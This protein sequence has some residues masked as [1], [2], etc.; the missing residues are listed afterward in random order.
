MIGRHPN[1]Q[2]PWVHR[3]RK[4]TVALVFATAIGTLSG[5]ALNPQPAHALFEGNGMYVKGV[6][7]QSVGGFWLGAYTAPHN[8]ETR[9][10]VWCTHM[11]RANPKP[12]DTASITDLGESKRW[13]PDELDLSTAQMA[14]L[15]DRYQDDRHQENRAALSFLIHA[16]FE[17]DQPGKNTQDSVNSL[18]DGVRHQLPQVFDRAKDYVRQAKESAVTTYENG[19]VETQT[20]RSG[21]LKD[22]GVKNEKGEWIPKLKLHLMLIGPARF[23][24]TGTSQWDGETQ[25]NAL[26]LEWEA[27]GNGT[28]KWVGN[29]ENPVR[30]TLTKYGVNPATQDT[31]SYGNRP[32]GDKEEKRLKGG[33]WKVLMDFQ[34]MGRSQVAQT[35]VKDNTLSDTVTAFADPNYG[36]GKWINDEHGPIPVTFEGTAY[37][38]GTEPPN[39]P[40]DTRFISK[41]MRV[42]GSTTVVFRGEGERQVSIPL[43]EGQAK[44]GFVSWVWRVRKEDQGQYSPLIHADW[45]DQLGLTHETQVIPW[46]IQI[47]SAAQLKETNGG[48]FLI[49]DLWVSGFPEGHTYWSGSERIAADTS[50]MRHRLL[51]FPQGLEVVEENREK[52]EE[53]GAV[54]VPAKNGYYP[55]L[56]DLRFTVDPQRIGTYVFTTEFD[57][58]GRVEAFR[59]SVEDPHEQ[60]TREA[61]SIIR[62]ATRARDGGDG[63]QVIAHLG[64]SK[65]VDQVC[66]EGLEAGERYSLKA[67][68]VDRESGEPLSAAGRPVEGT[69]DFTAETASGCAEVMINV[70]GEDIKAKSVVIFEDLFHGDQ[71]I[72]FHRDINAAQQTLNVEQPKPPK[73]ART[74]TPGVLIISLAGVGALAGGVLYRRGRK[75]C[76]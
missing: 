10:P 51:F 46:K 50:H 23:T 57:G 71:R 22:L 60:Y 35:S 62:L 14:W 42:L 12:Q 69:A 52:A 6:G 33:T 72:A 4:G 1:I 61:P 36:D 18:V 3:A 39:E 32:G 75:G 38:L 54:E 47:H 53:I 34:P 63:D 25:G 44:P 73:V 41:D 13:G 26:S 56:G 7:A 67:N 17:G 59:S 66:Y 58:D 64:A 5:L 19:I 21:V 8:V 55:S 16:N 31:A 27:T 11:W 40:L 15:L 45:A 28:V 29:Y 65:I 2:K 37:D 24:S 76:L 20:P 9:Y 74:G 48:D 49:D 70:Q 30:S 68:V 43:P